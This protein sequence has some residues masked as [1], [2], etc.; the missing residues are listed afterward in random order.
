MSAEEYLKSDEREERKKEILK[1]ASEVVETHKER[2]RPKRSP[3]EIQRMIDDYREQ[4]RQENMQPPSPEIIDGDTGF[5]NRS[6]IIFGAMPQ[7]F[8]GTRAGLPP[9]PNKEAKPY[10]QQSAP[11]T[12]REM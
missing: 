1:K 4:L 6:E 2:P 9:E 12:Q 10:I 11:P 8:K 3:Q 7:R 5:E